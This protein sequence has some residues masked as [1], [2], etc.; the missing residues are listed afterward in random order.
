MKIQF[1]H[2]LDKPVVQTKAGKIR[3]FQMDGVYTFYGIKYAQANRFQ[4]PRPVEP[5]EGI[6]NATSFGYICPVIQNSLPNDEILIAHRFW[7][8][9]EDCQNLNIWTKS[10]D[11]A[12]KRPVMVWIHGGTFSAGSSIEM[13]AYDG[14]QMALH[15]DVV[16]ITLNHRLNILGYLDMSSFDKKYENSV[17]AGIADLV[18]A[19][20]WIR[21]NIAAFGGDPQNVT[22]M[23]QSGGGRKV[24][25]LLQSPAAAGLFHKAILQS[26]TSEWNPVSSEHHRKLI[27]TILGELSLKEGD[28]EKLER[29]PY[30]ALAR[31]YRRARQTL[32]D[33]DGTRLSAPG[34]FTPTKNGWFLGAPP[35]HGFSDYAKTV[36]I[37]MGSVLCEVG[38]SP[39][40]PDRDSLGA[41]QKKALL[42]EIYG[43]NTDRLI[44]L[45]TRAYPE[46][47]ELLLL[48]FDTTYRFNLL[49]YVERKV[50]ESTAPLFL[51]LLG[52]EFD[53]LGGKG[54]WHC[55]EI[56]FA[57]RQAATVPVYHME[58]VME[59]L[60]GEMSGAWA[61]FARTGDPSHKGLAE[62]WPAYNLEE[63]PVMVFDKTSGVKRNHEKELV[64]LHKASSGQQRTSRSSRPIP[65]FDEEKWVY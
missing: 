58:G 9:N 1:Q 46:K 32:N 52:L 22:I 55:S 5:W 30:P 10:L 40:I 45:F 50:S 48:D 53:Y 49:N 57:F 38:S 29:V 37:L 43:E 25:T 2:T 26:G 65:R 27:I 4:A 13:P 33:Q 18:Q 15:E 28:Y 62:P 23:G 34:E 7:P 14:D 59:K 56:P 61:S 54:A 16:W 21:E 31:A 11:G 63:R 51:Y 60:Q 44:E 64:E 8:E 6:K 42:Q 12:D 41:P 47:N 17:N 24:T 39:A 19:L 3:G 35:F 36:P 20:I